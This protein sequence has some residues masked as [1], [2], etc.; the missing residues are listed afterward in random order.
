MSGA[1]DC[2]QCEWR[3]PL[4]GDCHSRCLN[5]NASVE[6]HP[7]G[8]EKGWFFWP[9]NFDPVWLVACDSFKARE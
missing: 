7:H 1:P 4:P 3:R 2:Y 5:I 8:I 9:Y 6:G